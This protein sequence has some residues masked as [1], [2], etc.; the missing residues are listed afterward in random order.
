MEYSAFHRLKLA[1]IKKQTNDHLYCSEFI[2]CLF[3]K[4]LHKGEKFV[5]QI[6]R[7]LKTEG[8]P[9]MWDRNATIGTILNKLGQLVPFVCDYTWDLRVLL[10]CSC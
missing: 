10:R 1:D 2:G 4:R 9:G 6:G 8:V 3:F 7:V 5:K